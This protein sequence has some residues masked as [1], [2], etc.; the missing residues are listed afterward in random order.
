MHVLFHDLC[1]LRPH[2]TRWAEAA[3]SL[4]KQ[5]TSTAAI[6]VMR[7]RPA[8]VRGVGTKGRHCAEGFCRHLARQKQRPFLDAIVFPG[9]G[10]YD[11]LSG[12][13]TAA[14]R[15]GWPRTRSCCWPKLL[16]VD[17][18]YHRSPWSLTPHGSGVSYDCHRDEALAAAAPWTGG[19]SA[20]RPGPSKRP[21]GTRLCCLDFRPF[22]SFPAAPPRCTIHLSLVTLRPAGRA[23]GTSTAWR[24]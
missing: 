17:R 16:P 21:L 4:I 18:N 19:C 7:A 10:A 3:R 13:I 11:H 23:T 5:R 20:C 9:R 1:P 8:C 12:I 15:N 24:R 6:E 2:V 22:L 14:D